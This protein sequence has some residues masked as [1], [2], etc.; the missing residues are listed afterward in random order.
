VRAGRVWG[1][2]AAGVEGVSGRGAGD[3]VRG[4]GMCR[5][6]GDGSRGVAKGGETEIFV[7]R[8][9]HRTLNVDRTAY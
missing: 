1:V 2:C 4:R 7:F 9:E 5:T 6:D 8:G 3:G